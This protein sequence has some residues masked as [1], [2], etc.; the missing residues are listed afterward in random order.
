VGNLVSRRVG[1]HSLFLLKG[2]MFFTPMIHV[3]ICSL[4]IS[5]YELQTVENSFTCL[6]H[7][8]Q[9]QLMIKKQR[10][11]PR[12]P[13]YSQSFFIWTQILKRLIYINLGIIVSN[14]LIQPHGTFGL[15]LQCHFQS[16]TT[17]AAH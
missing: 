17:S 1:I 6:E 12:K 9:K 8:M 5:L 2:K 10:L 3:S 4:L 7:H 16:R 14:C 13:L 15:Q 11:V